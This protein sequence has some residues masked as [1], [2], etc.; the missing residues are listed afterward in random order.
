[1]QKE[2][3][4][5]FKVIFNI[6]SCTEFSGL[7]TH[8]KAVNETLKIVLRSLKTLKEVANITMV[9]LQNHEMTFL[10]RNH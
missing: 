10:I 7:K 2:H 3:Q 1:M 6:P 4:F 5:Y 9:M 8:I